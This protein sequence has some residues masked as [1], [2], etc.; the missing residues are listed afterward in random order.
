LA[1]NKLASACGERVTRYEDVAL[2]LLCAHYRVS[3][4]DFVNEELGALATDTTRARRL[5][6][7]LRAYLTSGQ[8]GAACAASVGISPRTVSHRLRAC[9]ET[10]GVQI[11]D[12]S[13]ELH[14]ALRLHHLFERGA[15]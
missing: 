13:A 11:A 6:Q 7:T 9:E 5:R 15:L 1:A 14:T 10:L 2:E 8:N 4:I 3:P 12:R